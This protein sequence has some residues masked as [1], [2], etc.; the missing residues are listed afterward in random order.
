M[1]GRGID[2]LLLKGKNDTIDKFYRSSK[3]QLWKDTW[4]ECR[5]IDRIDNGSMSPLWQKINMGVIS[6]T[7]AVKLLSQLETVVIKKITGFR[8]NGKLVLLTDLYP[9]KGGEYFCFFKKEGLRWHLLQVGAKR[10]N[11]MMAVGT[12]SSNRSELP[13]ITYSKVSEEGETEFVLPNF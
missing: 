8:A 1:A 4:T 6:T 9:Q 11:E 3:D 2:M 13:M 7:E 10:V 12:D 5:N